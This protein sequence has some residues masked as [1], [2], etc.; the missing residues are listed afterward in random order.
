MGGTVEIALGETPEWP[1]P[2]RPVLDDLVGGW[3]P[4]V[5]ETLLKCRGSVVG[6]SG[7]NPLLT[8]SIASTIAAWIGARGRQVTLVDACLETPVI[9]K[10]LLDDGDEG[11]VDA[12]SFGVSTSVVT[13]RTLATSVNLVTA[14]SRA[15]SASRVLG[16]DAFRVVL[17]KL[18]RDGALVLVVLPR[19]DLERALWV[20]D[21]VVAV[22]STVEDISS[23]EDVAMDSVR[24]GLRN[25]VRLL[26][27]TPGVS[28]PEERRVPAHETLLQDDAPAD[29][30]PS[31]DVVFDGASRESVSDGGIS[32]GALLDDASSDESAADREVSDES[33]SDREVADES[34][35]DREVADEATADLDVSSETVPDDSDASIQTGV[36]SALATPP[37]PPSVTAVAKVKVRRRSRLWIP[38]V[39]VLIVAVLGVLS[40]NGLLE[41]R[42]TRLS[43]EGEVTAETSPGGTQSEEAADDAVLLGDS[44]EG[45]TEGMP[46][47]ELT[48]SALEDAG[49]AGAT[50]QITREPPPSVSEDA[51]AE[52]D[53]TPA[54]VGLYVVFTS[55][56]KRETAAYHDVGALLR[57]GLPAALVAIELEDSGVWYRVAVDAGFRTLGETT[58]LLEVVRELGYE[59]AWIERLRQPTMEIDSEE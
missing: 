49:V 56:H 55:S 15:I 54:S 11:L 59:G 14:G 10:A 22:G 27:G 26:V 31:G 37:E 48:E 25:V 43:D 29:E 34:A 16:A 18:A 36:T 6:V 52:F 20:L 41:P 46:R 19:E 51:D 24:P 58:E 30:R 7:S 50:T 38:L 2:V 47:E 21:C 23:V 28:A 45:V 35:V 40:H 4:D 9:A 44:S 13:R 17:D 57:S 12:V 53:W 42:V 8:A 1:V 5:E 33:A 3:M 32:A 39:A